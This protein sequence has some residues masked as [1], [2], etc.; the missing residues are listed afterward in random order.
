M[1]ENWFVYLQRPYRLVIWSR[2]KSEYKT[3]L[4][5]LCLYSF[6]LSLG[7]SITQQFHKISRVQHSIFFGKSSPCESFKYFI[8]KSSKYL[9]E[10]IVCIKIIQLFQII[11]LM[12]VL[13]TIKATRSQIWDLL[14]FFLSSDINFSFSIHRSKFRVDYIS[15]FVIVYFKGGMDTGVYHGSPLC[16]T[17]VS[18]FADVSIF[19]DF[20]QIS[21]YFHCWKLAFHY[22]EAS[23]FLT[24]QLSMLDETGPGEKA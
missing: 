10:M 8:M 17:D 20:I 11:N 12:L 5:C 13:K 16:L 15:I 9:F 23:F 19:I 18:V 3:I 7:F 24:S 21:N 4:D 6:W 14:S 2:A 22:E 1:S